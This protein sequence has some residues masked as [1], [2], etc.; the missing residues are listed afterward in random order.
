MEIE[1][2]IAYHL[3][4]EG[5]SFNY[6]RIRDD[7]TVV[8]LFK[9]EDQERPVSMVELHP[10]EVNHQKHFSLINQ[11]ETKIMLGQIA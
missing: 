7:L 4:T 8:T 5:Y 6:M 11:F 1:Y 2:G 3:S 10:S 9:D